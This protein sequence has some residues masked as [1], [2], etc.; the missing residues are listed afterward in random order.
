MDEQFRIFREKNPF[1][2]SEEQFNLVETDIKKER[3]G[4][5]SDEYVEFSLWRRGLPS[6]QES[7]ATYVMERLPREQYPN[8]LEV[9]AGRTV[10]LSKLLAKQGYRVTAMEPKIL[11]TDKCM[12]NVRCLKESFIYGKTDIAMYDAV[13]AQEPCEA[14]EHIVRACVENR[15]NFVMSLC[16]TPHTLMDGTELEDVDTWYRYLQRI[17]KEHC[18]LERPKLIPG[19]VSWVLMGKY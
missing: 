1:E 12:E 15:K 9:G 10:R 14:T 4:I 8:V 17:D 7:F 5:V 19:F 13:I 3:G 18:M 11:E 16:G 2:F 6:R